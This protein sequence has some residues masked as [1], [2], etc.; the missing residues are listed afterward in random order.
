MQK[1]SFMTP[2]VVLAAGSA[3]PRQ[4]S[5]LTLEVIIEDPGTVRELDLATAHW[6]YLIPVNILETLVWNRLRVSLAYANRLF[7]VHGSRAPS[8]IIVEAMRDGAFDFVDSGDPVVRW[9]EAI[10]KAAA[11][12]RLWLDLYGGRPSVGNSPLVGKSDAIQ[13]VVRTIR[14]VGPTAANILIIGESGTGKEKVAQALHETSGLK[15]PFLPLNCAA[16]PR[17]LIESELFG[18]EKGAFTGANQSRQGLVE[19]AAGGT[20]FLDEI[21]ELDVSLQPKLLRFLESRRARRVGG[22]SEYQVEARILAATNRDL[23]RRIEEN[24]FRADL[25]YR[26]SEIVIRIPPLRSHPEDIPLLAMH[27]LGEANE[28][29]GKNFVSIDPLLMARM[30][31][32]AWPGNARELRATVHRMVVL[33]HGPT[34]RVEWWDD[35]SPAAAIAPRRETEPQAQDAAPVAALNRRQKRARARQLLEESG[36]DQTWT[37]AQL[38]IHPTTLFRWIKSGQV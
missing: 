25:F 5:K 35:I 12:Q 23:E 19:Q 14:Q 9:G 3:L 33:H 13:A 8:A 7:I 16:I 26:L 21:G 28:K 17:E 22:R 1:I 34:L 30:M 27:F 4:I 10:E 2:H 31:K 15:G 37:A 32:G 18:S 36:N 29:Y 20:L 24:E 6:V 38:G 11:S